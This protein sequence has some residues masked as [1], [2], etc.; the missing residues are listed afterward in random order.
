[1]I[2]VIRMTLL[3]EYRAATASHAKNVSDLHKRIGVS[4]RHEYDLLRRKAEES[5]HEAATAYDALETA[6]L[7]TGCDE[8]AVPD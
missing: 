4:S 1:M 5:R 6:S 2:C 3:D 8:E 7:Q